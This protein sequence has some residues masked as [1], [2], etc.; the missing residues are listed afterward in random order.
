MLTKAESHSPSVEREALAVVEAV[1]RWR[2]YLSGRPFTLITDQQAVSFMF[3]QDQ[4]SKVK[5]LKILRWRL[6]L[7][8]YSYDIVYRPGKLNAPADALSRSYC[9]AMNATDLCKLHADLCH[10]GITRLYHFIKSKNLPFS[11]DDVKT[12]TAS[13]RVC[14]EFKPK[15]HRPQAPGFLV[16]ATQPLERLSL[17]FKGPVPSVGKNRFFLTII[18]EYSRFPF[19]YPCADVSAQT[20]I[21]CLCQLFSMFGLPAYIHTD[22]GSAFMSRELKEFLSSRGVAT[23]RSTPYHP[24]GNGQCERYNGTIWKA[25]VLA[26]KTKGLDIAQWEAVVPD[27]LHSIRSLLCVATNCTPHE[28]MF[29]YNR[30]SS[31]GA[32]I[33]TWLTEERQ[34]FLRKY[35]KSSKYDNPVELVE[36]LDTNEL[37]AHI[38]H[39][40]GRET[41]VST[42]DLAPCPTRVVEN[43]ALAGKSA[44]VPADAVADLALPLPVELLPSYVMQDQ[45]YN[46]TP[47]ESFPKHPVS[48]EAVQTPII[49]VTRQ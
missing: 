13:C 18:D 9:S 30:R 44:H 2:H 34:V 17:D 14:A 42:R 28:R 37:Y 24:M 16:K 31:S 32:S 7:A 36:L 5:N 12:M 33:P 25:I 35:V 6:E 41:T 23:S 46:S 43:P 1:K 49:P 38:R 3:N 29:G 22:R 11:L 40:D 8:N 45:V 47:I 15:F 19:I 10:P 4:H 27:A 26:T 48:N 21:S 39:Q 20:V